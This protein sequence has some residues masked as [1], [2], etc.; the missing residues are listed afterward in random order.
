[1]PEPKRLFRNASATAM[2]AALAMPWPSSPVVTSMPQ[3]WSISGCPAQCEPST[4]KR[5]IS[6][7]LIFPYPAGWS[8]E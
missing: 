5:L 7:R 2:P 1:M 3:A 4:R 6:S 8:S